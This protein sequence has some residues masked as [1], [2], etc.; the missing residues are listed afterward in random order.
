MALTC[1]VTGCGSAMERCKVQSTRCLQTT[2]FRNVSVYFPCHPFLFPMTSLIRTKTVQK[3]IIAHNIIDLSPCL[4]PV[5]WLD[6]EHWLQVLL[7]EHRQGWHWT[8]TVLPQLATSWST[9]VR[10]DR[11]VEIRLSLD[12]FGSKKTGLFWHR[13]LE[14]TPF[15][16]KRTQ[17][18]MTNT[19]N[20]W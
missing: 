16:I 4:S 17:W 18:K 1:P 19:V 7:C 6:T 10:K 3:N 14:M 11:F 15:H 8:G 2:L 5:R 20:S 9:P 13:H 12:L